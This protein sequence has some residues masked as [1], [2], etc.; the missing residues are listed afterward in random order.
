MGD[1]IHLDAAIDTDVA[2]PDVM[3]T[4]N[5]EDSNDALQGASSFTPHVSFV[6][7][8]FTLSCLNHASTES[9]HET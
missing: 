2:K 3:A 8:D 4:V 6:N 5:V 1:F 9:H 7:L